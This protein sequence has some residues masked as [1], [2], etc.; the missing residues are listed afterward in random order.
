MNKSIKIVQSPF[1]LNLEVV[2]DIVIKLHVPYS[3]KSVT[4]QVNPNIQDYQEKADTKN[5][6]VRQVIMTTPTDQTRTL[7][8][9]LENNKKHR[10]T[11]EDF[12]YEIELIKIG[13]E[14][15][16]GQD[17]PYYEFNVSKG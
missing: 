12:D 1:N 16:Q 5:A 17:F 13:K 2:E 11:I 7:S 6:Q 10:I 3:N 9:D 8:F 15:I 14:N 4:I